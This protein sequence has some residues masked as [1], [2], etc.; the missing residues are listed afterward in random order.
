[1]M[2][3]FVALYLACLVSFV[4]ATTY[5]LTLTDDLGESVT[6]S[7]EP[8]RIV[9][10]IP[11]HTETLCALDACDKLVGVDQFSNYPAEVGDLPDMGSAFSPNLEAIIALKPDLVLADESSEVAASLR[12]AGVPV[13]AGT[14]QTFEETFEKFAVLGELVNRE[15]EAALLTGEVE[16]AIR[17]ISERAEGLTPTRFYYEIDA[18]PYS[19]G[20]ISFIGT[21]LTLAGGDNIVGPDLGDFPQLE[22]EFIVAADP[23]V[24]IVSE[25]DFA[26]LPERPGWA[27][28]SAVAQD[29]VIPTNPPLDDAISRPGPRLA[30]AVRFFAQALHPEVFGAPVSQ[31]AAP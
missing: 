23:T 5:P 17:A 24:I 22:P 10:M 20:P 2:K 9:A 15:T 13:Y 11:S 18:T 16:G 12:R 30:L 4:S 3:S 1:M 21:L 29:R 25:R 8:K 14:A 6:L 27:N 31:P 7:A 26:A 19:V 28:I